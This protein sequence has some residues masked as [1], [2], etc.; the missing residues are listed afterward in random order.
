MQAH[1]VHEGDVQAAEFAIRIG[2]VVV[3]ATALNAAS[4]AAGE[5]DGELSRIVRV[6]VEETAG[7]HDHAVFEQGALTFIRGLHFGERLA[8]EFHLVLVHAL[9]HVEAVLVIGVMRQFMDAAADAVEAG[10]SHVGKIVI[11]HERGNAGAVHLEGEHHDVEHEAEMLL[12]AGWDARA[13]AF[14][15]GHFHRGL[16]A[17]TVGFCLADF[18]GQLDPLLDLAHGGE[19]FIELLFVALT[20]LGFEAV[21]VIEHEVEDALV[22]LAFAAVIKELVE[23]LLGEDFLWCRRRRRAPRDVG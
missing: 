16:P 6:A 23:G 4:T 20:E 21:R 14:E 15:R 2:A 7:E 8:P 9:I 17:G 1:A 22:A 5:D 3:E 19:V 18:F 10:E 12:A 13:G 11:H